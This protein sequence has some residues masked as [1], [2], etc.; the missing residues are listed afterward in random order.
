M[1]HQTF[2]K[3]LQRYLHGSCTAEEKRIV[4]RWYDLLPDE[5]RQSL[6]Q[7]DYEAIEER[8]WEK[9]SSATVLSRRKYPAKRIT[10]FWSAA[11]TILVLPFLLFLFIKS[12]RSIKHVYNESL[13]TLR[14]NLPDGSIVKLLGG[15][16][17]SYSSDFSPRKICL[18]GSALF[19]VTTDKLNPFRVTHGF[20]TTEVLGTEFLI[21]DNDDTN[22]SEVIVYSG[23]VQVEQTCRDV[24]LTKRLFTSSAKPVQLNTNEKAIFHKRREILEATIVE[25]PKPV[26][27]DRALFEHV[28][29]RAVNLAMLASKL[30]KMYALDIQVDA[31]HSQTTFTGNLD[32]L[33][34]FE[35]LDMICAVTS[36]RYVVQNR[37]ISI[38]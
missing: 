36:T 1:S 23:K 20:M 19:D 31:T 25:Q 5:E 12:E 6:G 33:G 16:H 28:R 4:E 35:Q 26:I 2:K 8:L 32:N 13:D 15:S 34:L 21:R 27:S 38:L 14:V 11:A 22:E 7:D 24:S 30:S 10:Q 18:Q 29:Y 17:V 37:K 3:L 9:V